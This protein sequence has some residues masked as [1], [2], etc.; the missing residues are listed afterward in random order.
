MACVAIKR[1]KV[2]NYKRGLFI[3]GTIL[4]SLMVFGIFYIYTNINSF[5]MMFQRY[6][7]SGQ[8]YW[9]FENFK[10]V[11]NSFKSGNVGFINLRNTSIY[12]FITL[13]VVTVTQ[14][15]FSYFSY[16]NLWGDTTRRILGAITSS[17]NGVTYTI[18]YLLYFN[19]GGPFS[20]LFTAVYGLEEPAQVLADIRFANKGL[21][22]S[23]CIALFGMSFYYRAAMMR[24][25]KEVLEYAQ[26]D[27]A[28]WLRELWSILLP[29]CWP[30]MMTMLVSL[31]IGFFNEGP[32]IYLMT[33]GKNDT[34][35]IAYW[36]Y[37]LQLG[38]APNSNS[39][40]F[41]CTLGWMMTGIIAPLTYLT[42][43]L[44]GKV[45]VEEY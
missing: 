21:I 42:K 18:I 8:L 5:F 1:R 12:W 19:P 28:S 44:L 29:M 45:D 22:L 10:L 24:I 9:T 43:W 15:I 6:D 17:M 16:K 30:V 7:A 33:G 27:G 11:I 40:N 14:P 25:P 39:L 13:V 38:A 41:L 31:I 36:L 4:P 20:S 2:K 34:G 32:D 35:T 26:L 37:S 3:I 23:S